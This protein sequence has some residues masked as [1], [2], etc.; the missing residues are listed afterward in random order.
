MNRVSRLS[1]FIECLTAIL[2]LLAVPGNVGAAVQEGPG[3]AITALS[4]DK[5]SDRLFKIQGQLLFE[6]KDSGRS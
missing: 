6:S 1:H 4:Y 3:V 5:A 2:W